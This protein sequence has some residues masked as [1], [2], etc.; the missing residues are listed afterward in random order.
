MYQQRLGDIAMLQHDSTDSAAGR[1]Q[2]LCGKLSPV[3]HVARTVG[4]C[5]DATRNIWWY[6]LSW[7]CLNVRIP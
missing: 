4:L 7:Y 2:A 5:T 1:Q 6:S 3:W